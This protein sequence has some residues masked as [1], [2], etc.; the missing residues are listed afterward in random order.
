LR[1]QQLI[2]GVQ[3]FGGHDLIAPESLYG[4]RPNIVR[5]VFLAGRAAFRNFAAGGLAP[6]LGQAMTA[7]LRS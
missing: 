6:H 3:G 2:A 1:W 5:P 7:L 4:Y